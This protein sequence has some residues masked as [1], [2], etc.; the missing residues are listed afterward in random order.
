MV[1]VTWEP[2][3]NGSGIVSVRGR[4]G[5][6]G[7]RTISFLETLPGGL[8]TWALEQPTGAWG[9][10]SGLWAP[11]G[12]R[13]CLGAEFVTLGCH[14]LWDSD[15]W[16]AWKKEK[17]RLLQD[18]EVWDE[19]NTDDKNQIYW[20]MIFEQWSAFEA[21]SLRSFDVYIYACETT[22]L[23]QDME[24]FCQPSKV[25]HAPGLGQ[26]LIFFQSFRSV[27]IFQKFM[28]MEFDSV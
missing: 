20:R 22:A 12:P 9:M 27:S 1:H 26:A 15:L 24:H 17:V 21:Y 10:C 13:P 16:D 6:Q 4:V 8:C 5:R 14:Q 18:N 28:L 25:P 7:V 23:N 2:R 19:V 11:P 3:T